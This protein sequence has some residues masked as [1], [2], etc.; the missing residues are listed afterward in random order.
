MGDWIAGQHVTL[1]QTLVTARIYKKCLA[2]RRPYGYY[3]LR[4]KHL[5]KGLH[6][7]GYGNKRCFMSMSQAEGL[8]CDLIA[9][10]NAILNQFLVTVSNLHKC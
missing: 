3:C 6:I 10:R 1:N 7:V 9:E 5:A 8:L 2:G 4:H